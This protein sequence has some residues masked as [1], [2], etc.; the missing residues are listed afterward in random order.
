MGALGSD[1]DPAGEI[2]MPIAFTCPHCGKA[3]TVADQYAGQS[4][5]C[6][7][8]GQTI[9]IPYH[10]PAGYG[11]PP[12]AKSSGA[13]AAIVIIIVA[14]LAVIGIAAVCLILPIALLLPAVQ[15][16][17]TAARSVQSQNNMK[18][19]L[20]AL[21][22]YHDNHREFPPAIVKDADGKPLYSGMVL[23]L[24]Y[25]GLD[26]VYQQF[27]KSKPWDADENRHLS[28]MMLAVFQNPSSPGGATPGRTDYL[29]VGGP[30]SALDSGGKSTLSDIVDGTSNTMVLIEVKGSTHSWAE[31]AAWT[32]DKPFDSDNPRGVNLGM[33][34]GSVRTLPKNFPRSQLQLLIQRDDGQP[35]NL[36]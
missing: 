3:T 13:G 8:C 32:I 34:D 6:S 31:P 4:G 27:D 22:M 1:C 15:T 20:L 33:A 12:P 9:T 10:S 23:L 5:P 21:H 30:K 17:R 11:P 29:F 16:A 25:L 7:G 28:S 26:H 35:V 14:I 2:T 24:P 19:I 36:P 18:Q